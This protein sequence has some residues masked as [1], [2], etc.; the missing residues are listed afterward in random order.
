MT[1]VTDSRNIHWTV[2]EDLVERYVMGRLPSTEVSDLEKHLGECTR[3]REVVD[4]ERQIVDGVRLAGRDALKR[5]LAQRVHNGRSSGVNWYRIAGVAAAIVFLVT[6]GI[7]NKW[8]LGGEPQKSEYRAGTDSAAPTIKSEPRQPVLAEKTPSEAQL[9]DAVKSGA[10]GKQDLGRLDTKGELKGAVPGA[11]KSPRQEADRSN[12]I[13][14]SQSDKPENIA[15]RKERYAD[16]SAVAAGEELW[17]QGEMIPEDRRPQEAGKALLKSAEG[18]RD[19]AQKKKGEPAALMSQAA[20][21]RVLAAETLPL[22][23]TQRRLSD[24]PAS[25]RRGQQSPSSVQT[26]MQKSASGF[27]LTLF[28]DSLYAISKH[29][30]PMIQKIRED[31]IVLEVGQQRIGYRIPAGWADQTRRESKKQK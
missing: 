22:S 5:R 25:Q 9:A 15:A 27:R 18:V 1:K 12:I 6:I 19:E 29:A 8:F 7:Y 16:L 10:S 30:P 28:L 17:V 24:L 4:A 11:D 14:R 20:R 21:T 23:I 2:D 3:C 31:S 26:L 13:A